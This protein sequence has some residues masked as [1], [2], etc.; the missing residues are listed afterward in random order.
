MLTGVIDGISSGAADFAQFGGTLNGTTDQGSGFTV[1]ENSEL[2]HIGFKYLSDDVLSAST[3]SYDIK[4][5]ESNVSFDTLP[6]DTTASFT[7]L[8]TVLT[9]TGDGA[10]GTDYGTYPFA[11]ITLGA[12]ITLTAGKFYAIVGERN[13]TGLFPTGEEAQITLRITE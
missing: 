6:A 9:I 4:V 7:S 1:F 5:Y 2:T 11:T 13:G 8:G 12:P 10:G 3:A